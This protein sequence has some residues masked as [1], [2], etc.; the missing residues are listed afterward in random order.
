MRKFLMI[1]IVLTLFSCSKEEDNNCNCELDGNWTMRPI[2]IEE[3]LVETGT[4]TFTDEILT[5]DMVRA[6]STGFL[7]WTP[8]VEHADI[9]RIECNHVSFSGVSW[10][11]LIF[12]NEQWLT[13]A[14]GMNDTIAID[15]NGCNTVTWVYDNNERVFDRD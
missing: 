13:Q 15:F 9:T 11:Y 7:A 8:I 14:I 1:S 10:R 2:E 12:E 4:L 3:N 5:Y 6:D